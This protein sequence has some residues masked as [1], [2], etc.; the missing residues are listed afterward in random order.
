MSI[1]DFIYSGI[2]GL[3]ELDWKTESESIFPN[4]GTEQEHELITLNID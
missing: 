3:Y 2:S 4:Q 1:N